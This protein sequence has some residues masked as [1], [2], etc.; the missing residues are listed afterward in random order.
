MS[1]VILDRQEIIASSID[2]FLGNVRLVTESVKGDDASL[3]RQRLQKCLDGGNLV[4]FAAH[5][6]LTQG[7][8]T[9]RG[10]GADQADGRIAAVT[11]TAN[12]LA[13]ERDHAF[14]N[15]GQPGD[16]VPEAVLKDS[17]VQ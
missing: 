11:R 3:E 12:R 8:A 14:D 10:K 17:G 1:L 6:F 9:G 15:P 7:K 13:I 2:D 5:A 16:P 4:A